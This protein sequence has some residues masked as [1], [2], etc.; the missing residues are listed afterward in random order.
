MRTILISISIIILTG[1][2]ARSV[3]AGHYQE[4]RQFL[5]H[6]KWVYLEMLNLEN[7]DKEDLGHLRNTLTRSIVSMFGSAGVRVKVTEKMEDFGDQDYL[8]IRVHKIVLER[9]VYL[10]A[11]EMVP[12]KEA[13]P[14]DRKASLRY[15]DVF[16]RFESV[17][18]AVQ[19][20]MEKMVSWYIRN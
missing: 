6:V 19:N 10:S 5:L 8:L 14:E 4:R 3:S 13:L 9:I 12:G 7:E 11:I 16:D 1:A 17:L 20:R 2:F 18:P 15:T